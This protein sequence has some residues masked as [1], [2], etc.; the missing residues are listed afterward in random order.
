MKHQVWVYSPH[1]FLF[2]SSFEV[3]FGVLTLMCFPEEKNKE[4]GVFIMKTQIYWIWRVPKLLCC[5]FF[6]SSF[7]LK[8]SNA[9]I[10]LTWRWGCLSRWQSS[11]ASWE[12]PCSAPTSISSCSHKPD[13]YKTWRAA[14]K[15]KMRVSITW[16]KTPVALFS[17]GVGESPRNLWRH[18]YTLETHGSTN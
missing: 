17:T 13:D 12:Q 2:W 18:S 15:W 3:I 6:L 9:P 14:T 11:L 1:I 10:L 16:N 4:Q 5:I 8:G 7:V